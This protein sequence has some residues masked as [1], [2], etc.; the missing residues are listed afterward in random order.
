MDGTWRFTP[1]PS[2]TSPVP[3]YDYLHYGFWIDSSE[4]E[5]GDPVYAV[6]TFSGGSME[7]GAGDLSTLSGYA[8]K[9]VGAGSATY[10]ARRPRRL[11]AEDRLRFRD[12]SSGVR[13]RRLL[14]GGCLP[15]GRIRHGSPPSPKPCTTPSRAP[16]ITSRMVSSILAGTRHAEIEGIRRRTA[17]LRAAM[18]RLPEAGLRASSAPRR[19]SIM[20]T[21]TTIR[22]T[23]VP[24]P[25]GVAGEFVTHF[26]NGHAAGAYGATR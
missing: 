20:M 3:D 9:D 13:P 23:Q 22:R 2:A 4:D 18:A 21:M 1:D 26:G 24:M 25:T 10:K 7:F 15:H 5:D 12:R 8:T 6:Q 16:W 14:H 17:R 19:P 11:C